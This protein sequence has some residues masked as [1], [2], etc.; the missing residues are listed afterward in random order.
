M[1]PRSPP[2]PKHAS[3]VGSSNPEPCPLESARISGGKAGNSSGY[4]AAEKATLEREKEE[5]FNQLVDL[6]EL[7]E[8][9]PSQETSRRWHQANARLVVIMGKLQEMDPEEYEPQAGIAGEYAPRSGTSP[10]TEANTE[11]L[12]ERPHKSAPIPPW[13]KVKREQTE[14]QC[15][16]P[17]PHSAR[18][19]PP[20]ISAKCSNSKCTN[21]NGKATHVRLGLATK[22]DGVCPCG[23]SL[24]VPLAAVFQPT[25]EQGRNRYIWLGTPRLFHGLTLTFRES[26][27]GLFVAHSYKFSKTTSTFIVECVGDAWERAGFAQM[28]EESMIKTLG[29]IFEE[30]LQGEPL[31]TNNFVRWLNFNIVKNRVWHHENVVL[32]GDA[33]HTAHFSIGSGT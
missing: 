11:P 29:K 28:S 33:L 26:D 15:E 4:V 14:D 17:K 30:D 20:E 32:L 7:H 12:G 25:V 5:I 18:V 6:D 23:A 31:L 3:A 1:P 13:K 2:K 19:R 16:P 22:S 27:A 9:R 10:Y 21:K 8:T 24:S